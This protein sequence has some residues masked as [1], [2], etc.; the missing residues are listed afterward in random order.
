MA[1]N[2][3]YGIYQGVVVNINDPEKRG[4]IKITCPDVLGCKTVSAWCDPIIPVAYDNGGDFYIPPKEET[5]WVLFIGGDPNKPAYLGGWWQKNMSP[6]GES[7]T[8][9]NAVRIVSFADC[10]IVM[11]KGS[12]NVSVGDS[13][14]MTI[15]SGKVA[16]NGNLSVSG[17]IT[18]GSVSAGN[19]YANKGKYGGGHITAQGNI[20]ASGTVHGSN[21]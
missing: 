19:I 5:V 7:Y 17:S 8:N 9:L 6:L 3:Y 4:R 15:Q 2:K 1:E 20:T 10:R 14:V 21:I 18:A 13:N 11:Q 16:V 12:I